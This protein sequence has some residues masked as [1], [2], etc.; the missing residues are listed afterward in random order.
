MSVSKSFK[1]IDALHRSSRNCESD[2][3]QR[4]ARALFQVNVRSTE[5][6]FD[7]RNFAQITRRVQWVK[8]SRKQGIDRA[9]LKPLYGNS[10]EHTSA[11][12]KLNSI[13][14]WLNAWKCRDIHE[15]TTLL[16]QPDTCTWLPNTKPFQAWRNVGNSFLWLNGKGGRLVFS[17]LL[18]LIWRSQPEP[19]NPS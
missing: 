11:A 4:Q 19:E 2:A 15:R 13:L 8:A 10:E 6:A 7:R 14:E 16:R 17:N 3:A 12:G 1:T 9:S 18:S 5:E